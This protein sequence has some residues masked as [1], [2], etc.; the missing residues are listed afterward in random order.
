MTN[1]KPPRPGE[2]QG[3]AALID[4]ADDAR[5]V[6]IGRAATPWRRGD[7]PKNM[8]EAR[9]RGQT[10][11]LHIDTPWRAALLDLDRASH[12]IVFGWLGNADRTLLR[13]MPSHLNRATGTFAL[14]SPAR[15]NPIGLS[16]ARIISL[17]TET[18]RVDLE[19]LDW[20]DGTPIV[21]LKPYFPSIDAFPEAD[22]REL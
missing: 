9:K 15:P 19:A 17:D 7:C 11:C 8:R 16:I 6:F 2:L 4:T 21:D 12:L 13:Q 20:F 1:A 14:R 22:V 5:L 3:N 18:G 10:A